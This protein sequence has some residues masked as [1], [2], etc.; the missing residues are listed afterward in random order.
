[1]MTSEA[2]EARRNY[3]REWNKNNRDKVKAAQERYWV[4]RAAREKGAQKRNDTGTI[5]TG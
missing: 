5:I 3:K 4:R 1:M 2:M